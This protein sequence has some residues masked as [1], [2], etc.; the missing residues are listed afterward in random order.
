MN[1]LEEE[2]WKLFRR[3]GHAY[4]LP[5]VMTKTMA[6][7]YMQPED[8]S[9]EVVAKKTGYSLASISNVVRKFEAI[10]MVL[11][12]RKPGSRKVYLYME[13]NLAKLNIQKIRVAKNNFITP[14]K[15]LVPSI[16]DKNKV[17]DNEKSKKQVELL[18]SY[19]DQLKIFES[20][21]DK[22]VKD[23][24]DA[25]YDIEKNLLRHK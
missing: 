2:C 5:D 18:K 11:K 19:Y 13:K 22:W 3:M 7:L 12:R 21:M 9:M 16:I 15:N 4:D 14:T 20:L 23:L 1:T 6:V 17:V 10:S 24:E 25:S 8:I